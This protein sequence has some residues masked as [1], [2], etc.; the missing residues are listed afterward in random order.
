[1]TGSKFK[2]VVLCSILELLF[3]TSL[4]PVVA[5]EG[6][7]EV[8]RIKN[9]Q[10]FELEPNNADLTRKG[11]VQYFE[12]KP[13][14]ADV[15]RYKN[16]QYFEIKPNSADVI[17]YR[18]L[19]C[20]ELAEL[21]SSLTINITSLILTDQDRN[22]NT[23]YSPGD[24]LQIDFIIKNMGCV[25]LMRGLVATIVLSPSNMPSFLSYTFVDLPSGLSKEFIVGY[26]IPANADVG[27]YN[28]RVLIFTDW[29]S[30]GG[31]GLTVE[32]T[33]FTVS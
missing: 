13:T 17:R 3:I 10:Y 32:E 25:Y 20:L 27:I 12:L 8:T 23:D 1:M 7:A 19:Q 21:P 29:P 24:V 14:N 33:A 18:N 5:E 11:N 9:L 22:P 31:Y 28:V 2:L 15:S 30:E 26:R 6:N 16:L 4:Q